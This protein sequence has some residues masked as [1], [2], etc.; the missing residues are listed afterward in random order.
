MFGAVQKRLKKCLS[1]RSWILFLRGQKEQPRRR[2]Q[3]SRFQEQ[4]S[5]TSRVGYNRII[6]IYYIAFSSNFGFSDIANLSNSSRY[7]AIWSNFVILVISVSQN[8]QNLW[9]SLF[10]YRKSVKIRVYFIVKSLSVVSQIGQIQAFS[11]R[12]LIIFQKPLECQNR[13]C[14]NPIGEV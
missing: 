7:I 9:Y 10:L 4:E 3:I 8:G 14:Y 6:Y 12:I 5:T 1:P 2:E 11:C 13:R